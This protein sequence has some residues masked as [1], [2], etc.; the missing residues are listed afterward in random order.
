MN[1][2]QTAPLGFI[3]FAIQAINVHKKEGREQIKFAVYA[4]K[5]FNF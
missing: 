1:P 5:W 3:L 4:G 2:D